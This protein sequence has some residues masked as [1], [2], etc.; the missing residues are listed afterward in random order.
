MMD[1]LTDRIA[2]LERE[3]RRLQ[4]ERDSAAPMAPRDPLLSAV[5]RFFHRLVQPGALNEAM[6]QALLHLLGAEGISRIA[7][8]RNERTASGEWVHR[9]LWEQTS[10]GLSRLL[11]QPECNPAPYSAFPE[12]VSAFQQ[13]AAY[14]QIFP[15]EM[16]SYGKTCQAAAPIK[17]CLLV[18]VRHLGEWWGVVR[19]DN[20]VNARAWT[21]QEIQVLQSVASGIAAALAREKA[22]EE[23]RAAEAAIAH[24]RELTAQAR[25]VRLAQTNE[26]FRKSLAELAVNADLNAYLACI[27][28]SIAEATGAAAAYLFEYDPEG[29]LLI[30]LLRWKDGEVRLTPFPGEP[31]V[32]HGPF[33]AEITD[34]F[35]ILAE[36]KKIIRATVS[37]TDPDIVRNSWPGVVDWHL[38][39][40]RSEA[41]ANLLWVGDQPAGMLGLA[42]TSRRLFSP[43]E[44]ELLQMLATQAAL[45]IKFRRFSEQARSAAI[46]EERNRVAREIH[47]TLAQSFTGVI[48]QL[49]A[50]DRVIG[51][52]PQIAQQHVRRAVD[53]A[54][55]GLNDARDSVRALRPLALESA[56][57]ASALTSLL[58]EMTAGLE[59]QA[60]FLMTGASRPLAHEASAELL[61]LGQEAVTNVL[62]HADARQVLVELM[63]LDGG[64]LRLR[65]LDDGRGFDPA[66]ATMGFGVRGMRERAA[67]LGG[68]LRIQSH[69]G[70]GTEIVF[71]LPASD[72][73]RR[74]DLSGER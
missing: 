33:S 45:A 50:A 61:R 5:T 39:E 9:Y 21:E 7:V 8:G 66:A 42:F 20:C 62:R 28:R 19:F 24:E 2:E 47:D 52:S 55:A 6:S 29:S 23:A 71:D 30:P 35:R 40:G 15:E 3:I 25:A 32:L 51:E 31:A 34:S 38:Q 1:V 58:D 70:E 74:V 64:G 13:G 48:V 54:R 67:R 63:W 49:S 22:E 37:V 36:S 57:L 73:W 60:V 43:E 14:C 46:L 26:V 72:V 68:T 17:V 56:D 18:A 12:T 59:L 69:P 11:D 44:T 53:L 65:I 4:A 27:L 10:P 41:S 16:T